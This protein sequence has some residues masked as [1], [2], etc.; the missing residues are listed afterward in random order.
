[1]QIQC[2][3]NLMCGR[4]TMPCLVPFDI[5]VYPSCLCCEI[6]CSKLLRFPF[7]CS[8]YFCFHSTSMDSICLRWNNAV[9]H[10]GIGKRKK[11]SLSL[12]LL[13]SLALSSFTITDAMELAVKIG[14]VL[15]GATKPAVQGFSFDFPDFIENHFDVNKKFLLVCLNLFPLS[16]QIKTNALTSHFGSFKKRQSLI[17]SNYNSIYTMNIDWG[18]IEERNA[19]IHAHF[20]IRWTFS[21]ELVPAAATA[22]V[23]FVHNPHGP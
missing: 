7:K 2:V 8:F 4:C 20:T 18:W 21:L 12:S 22:F 14:F 17:S 6:V 16:L 23:S 1:M 11:L 3:Y 19:R 9:T 10:F 15:S 5:E 13:Y